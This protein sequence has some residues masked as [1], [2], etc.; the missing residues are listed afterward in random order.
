MKPPRQII[1]PLWP[2]ALMRV[3]CRQIGHAPWSNSPTCFRLDDGM[4][5]DGEDVC[6]RC[7]IYIEDDDGL[8]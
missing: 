6:A 4:A 2:G 5:I 8:R 7:G 3:I 1:K